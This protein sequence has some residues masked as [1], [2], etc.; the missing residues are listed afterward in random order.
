MT[1]DVSATVK[2]I[3]ADH[4]GID[5]QKVTD[6][7]SFID[8]LGAD[9]LDTVELVL[10]L[11]DQFGIEIPDDVTETL[12]TVADVYTYLEANVNDPNIW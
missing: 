9:S 10:E 12:F 2:R 11:E 5:E 4:L 7:A 3:V 8:D 6:E 1:K